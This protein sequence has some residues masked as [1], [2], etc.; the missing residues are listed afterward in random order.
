MFCEICKY[1]F[2]G[3]DMFK[4][5]DKRLCFECT[6]KIFLEMSKYVEDKEWI[7]LSRKCAGENQLSIF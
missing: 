6:K 1:D 3:K 7:E 5:F 4:F 2:E